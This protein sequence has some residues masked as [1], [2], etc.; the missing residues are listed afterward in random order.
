M[1]VRASRNGWMT[2]VEYHH[3]L[4]CVFKSQAERRILVVDSYKSHKSEESIEIAKRR[5]NSEVIIIPGGCTSIIQPMDKCINKPFKTYMRQEW[6]EWMREDRPTTK[7]GNLKQPTR[8]NI[9]NWVSKAWASIEQKVITDSFL[10]CG[11][12]NALDGS[13]DDLVSDDIPDLSETDQLDEAENP[14]DSQDPQNDCDD[15]DVDGMGD[16]FSD[17]S[18]EEED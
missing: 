17:D 2:R 4:Q 14:Q 7:A 9:V 18:E 15:S 10:V 12:A 13:E 8:Q 16:P 11:L 3:W 6:Q 1:Q 5:C